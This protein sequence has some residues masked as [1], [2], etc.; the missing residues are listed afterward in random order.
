LDENGV[1]RCHVRL[2]SENLQEHIVFP[3]LLPRSHVFS[4]LVIKNFHEKLMHAGVS[5]TLV[6]IR[7]EFWFPQGRSSV[8]RV[9][10]NCLRCRRHQGGPYRMP[11]MAPYPRSRIEESPLFT[12]TSWTLACESQS[13]I[14]NQKSLVVSVYLTV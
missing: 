3:K 1:L 6:A 8:R 11:A 5:H 12:F 2:I 9:L 10:L 14:S 4:S 13:A 7:R